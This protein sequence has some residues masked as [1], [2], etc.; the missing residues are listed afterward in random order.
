M[1]QNPAVPQEVR[2]RL[3]D[4]TATA[5]LGRALAALSAPGV[6]L[7]LSGPLG[8]GKTSLARA[9]L[10]AAGD[11]AGETIAEVPSPT[12]TLVQLY[13]IGLYRFWHFDLYRLSGPEEIVELGWDEALADIALVEWPER[14]GEALPRDR[15]EIALS[16]DGTARRAVL[17]GTGK[18]AALLS[19][20]ALQ[21]DGGNR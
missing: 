21:G 4:E 1:T 2:L 9:L 20:F 19:R 8:A 18:G 5:A 15:I 7:L 6:A 14:L 11:R 12:F 10:R 17:T 3:P 13:T 16:F